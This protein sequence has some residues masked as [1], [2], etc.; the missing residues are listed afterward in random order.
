MKRL[1][2]E[3]HFIIASCFSGMVPPNLGNSA[4]TSHLSANKELQAAEA[5]MGLGTAI[6]KGEYINVLIEF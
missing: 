3:H 5:T 2:H 6:E 4:F 1:V